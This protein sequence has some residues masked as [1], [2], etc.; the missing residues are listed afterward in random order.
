M[1]ESYEICDNC[2][3]RGILLNTLRN[4][5]VDKSRECLHPGFCENLIIDVCPMCKGHGQLLWIDKIIPKFIHYGSTLAIQDQL[6]KIFK[7][8]ISASHITV[9]KYIDEYC[10]ETGTLCFTVD[11]GR[12]NE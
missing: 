2:N 3:G 12:Y 1:K 4:H 8:D 5:W 9:S 7:D 6:S 10:D 11:K